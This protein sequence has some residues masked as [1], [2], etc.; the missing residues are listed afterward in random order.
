M[1][2]VVDIDR[3]GLKDNFV[4]GVD[5]FVKKAMTCPNFLAEGGMNCP[6]VNCNYVDLANPREVKFHLY[7]DEF[8]P[9]YYVWTRHG[10]INPNENFGG[11]SSRERHVSDMINSLQGG[12]VHT[13]GRKAH[14]NLALDMVCF[15]D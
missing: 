11:H 15:I 4:S 10:E 14:H 12:V 1:Y 2:D 9:N 13:T 6:C 5:E 8:K 3:H 7:R